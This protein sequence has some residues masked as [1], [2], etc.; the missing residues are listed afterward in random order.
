[1]A[2]GWADGPVMRQLSS[3]SY[4][5]TLLTEP[6]GSCR[7][8]VTPGRKGRQVLRRTHPLQGGW[9]GNLRVKLFPAGITAPN[10]ITGNW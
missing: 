5:V 10:L 8:K 2:L 4:Q 6:A 7:A 1:M 3:S 9:S